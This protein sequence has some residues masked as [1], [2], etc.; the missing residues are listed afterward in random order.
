MPDL[1]ESL[2]L[3]GDGIVLRDW[4]LED[5]L[6]L[7]PVC[8]EWNV[9]SFTSVPW[10]YSE[11]AARAWVGRQWQKRAAGTVLALAITEPGG[12]GELPVGNVNLAEFGE[13]GRS[14]SIGYWLVPAARGR[15]LA[16]VAVRL[17][18][19]WG[20]ESFRLERVEFAI[21]PE[22]LASQ[23]V[24]ERAGA[25]AKGLRERSHHEHG[26]WWDMSIYEI[27]Q[28]GRSAR[29]SPDL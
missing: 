24:A 6:A 4:R 5:A 19:D 15:G 13:D 23:R 27:T 14:A 2:R 22:N 21:L 26:R 1:P 17:L 11:D 25:V 10:D 3:E 16:V 20:F 9:S 8:G 12:G 29:T 28:G 7:E 18:I